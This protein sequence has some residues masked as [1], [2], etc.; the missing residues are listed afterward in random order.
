VRLERLISTA[1]EK[2]L[3]K[4]VVKR[5]CGCNFSTARLAIAAKMAARS[6]MT[7]MA[8]GRYVLDLGR[9]IVLAQA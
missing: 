5:T 9:E 3:K 7:V 6:S 1:V 4:S 2:R 8:G